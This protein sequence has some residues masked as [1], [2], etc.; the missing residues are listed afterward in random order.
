L[1]N[2]FNLLKELYEKW[3][4]VNEDPKIE[5]LE[6]HL[7]NDLKNK[8]IIIFTESKE[9]AFYLEKQLKLHY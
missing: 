7:K 4:Q 6:Y 1:Y 5:E 8:K 3:E 9:T 2:D